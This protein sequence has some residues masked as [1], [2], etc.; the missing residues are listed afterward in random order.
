MA[1]LMLPDLNQL[2]GTML[3]KDLRE[4]IKV[5]IALI[6]ETPERVYGFSG[7]GKNIMK[8]QSLCIFGFIDFS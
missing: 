6:S 8:K 3:Y 1:D 4:E 2:L 5:L 7:L